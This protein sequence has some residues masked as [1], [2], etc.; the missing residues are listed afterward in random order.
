MEKVKKELAKELD[1]YIKAKHTQEECIGFI[2]GFE[3]AAELFAL[4]GVSNLREL[5]IAYEKYKGTYLGKNTYN[6][7]TF[8]KDKY[9]SN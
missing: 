3:R 9:S 1:K 5:L 6:I 7:D 4:C 8:L 2:D